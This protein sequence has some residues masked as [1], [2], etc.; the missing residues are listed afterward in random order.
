MPEEMLLLA[1][2]Y[3]SISEDPTTGT[4]QKASAF[5]TRI[6]ILYNKYVSKANSNRSGNTDWKVLLEDRPKE[7]LKSQWYTRLQPA[8]QKF[9]GIVDKNLHPGIFVMMQKWIFI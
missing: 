9:A 2:S 3:I 6:H 4:N 7:S 5:W 8:I 1:Y